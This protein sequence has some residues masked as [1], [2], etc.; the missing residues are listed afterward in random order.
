MDTKYE[1]IKNDLLS[2]IK[3]G[4][5]AIGDKL[6][7]ES[8]LMETYGVSRYTVRRAATELENA[9]YAY[10]I[11]GGGM[12][13]DNWAKRQADHV[14][15]KKIG[16]ITTHLADY[17]FPSIISG[18]ERV[19]SAEGYSLM[20]T[21]THNDHE[22]ERVSLINMLNAGIDGLIIEP[23]LSAITNPNLD[24]YQKIKE[25]NIPVVVI[26]A[27][28]DDKNFPVVAIDDRRAEFQLIDY[29]LK[30]GHTRIL[31]VFKVDDIQ[32]VHRMRGFTE[33]YQA[34]PMFAIDSD[35][36]M[37]QSGKD[38]VAK[39]LSKI[40]SY[41]EEPDRPTA[42]AFYNDELAIQVMDVIRSLGLR[43]PDDISLVGFDD[44][45]LSE[46][47]DPGLTTTIHPKNKMGFDAAKMLFKLIDGQTVNSIVYEPQMVI[48]DSIKKLN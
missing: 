40:E 17:I 42:I 24:I 7:T 12:Y 43:I 45:Q 29:L 25:A 22:V 13:V 2:A 44:F 8:E 31:G 30:L 48:R 47:V 5:Y 14:T 4:Q 34:H 27:A 16:V 26:N 33:A 9:H 15:S 32:G 19:V 38:Q 23:T 39:M 46:Y 36:I 28:I 37:Y 6:P 20:I 1:K 11:Q 10:R 18:I 21:D 41:L 3:A 35:I